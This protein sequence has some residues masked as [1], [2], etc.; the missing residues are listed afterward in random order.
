MALFV[1]RNASLVR[2]EVDGARSTTGRDQQTVASRGAAAFAVH[3]DPVGGL[4][5]GDGLGAAAGHAVIAER[6]FEQRDE[7]GFGTG[8]QWTD[9]R[10][11][12]TKVSEELG[13]FDSD[14][15][16]TDDDQALR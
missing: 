13:L 16:G 8:Q 14:K 11:L 15:A 1:N 7:F 3:G 2:A 12:A 9:Q 10:D 6:G 5:D 4:L